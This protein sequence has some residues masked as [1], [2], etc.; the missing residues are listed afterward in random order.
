LNLD[1]V[2]GDRTTFMADVS[3]LATSAGVAALQAHGDLTWS[4]ATGFVLSTD[5]RLDNLDVPVSTRSTFAPTGAVAL[6]SD[7]TALQAH[8]DL[9]WDTAVGFVTSTDPRLDFLD[10][11]ITSRSTF[12]HLTD[13]VTLAAGQGIATEAT[14]LAIKAQTD[15]IPATPVAVADI[16]TAGEIASQ[17]D[18]TITASHGAGTY[19]GTSDA[20]LAKQDQILAQIA[21][22][23]PTPVAAIEVSDART[24]RLRSTGEGN[25]A[26]NLVTISVLETVTLAVDFSAMLNPEASITLVTDIT[27]LT[28]SALTTTNLVPSGRRTAAH[29]TVSGA[30]VGL[31]QLAVKVATTDGET[32]AGKVT[33][34][35]V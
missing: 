23:T 25:V 3:A 27:V 4:T 19:A 21:S 31:R 29:F 14:S 28:G 12:D 11:A 9:N 22:I 32:I 34:E 13:Q 33:I 30:L 16:P 35:V 17:V 8:G 24:W 2:T 15:L 7:L 18:A 1:N 6:Q 10:A 5:G 26:T 20:T